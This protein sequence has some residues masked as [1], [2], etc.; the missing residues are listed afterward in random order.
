MKPWQAIKWEGD[1]M[2]KNRMDGLAAPILNAYANK[3][4]EKYPDFNKLTLEQRELLV[5][6]RV[7]EPAK[8]SVRRMIR[9]GAGS[10]GSLSLLEQIGKKPQGDVRKVL[11]YLGQ[12]GS[13]AD[14]AKQD[15][16]KE[17]LETILYMIDNWDRIITP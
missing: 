8:E 4:M 17:K 6:T 14:I 16:G 11:K 1:P 5:K 13:L 7:I 2:V 9:T 12:E 10:E 15:G 3:L